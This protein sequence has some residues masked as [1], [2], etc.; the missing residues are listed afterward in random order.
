MNR[1]YYYIRANPKQVTQKQYNEFVSRYPQP[2]NMFVMDW[3]HD[4]E[5]I[6]TKEITAEEFNLIHNQQTYG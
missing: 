5:G 6:V 4:V 1:R 2:V 3:V